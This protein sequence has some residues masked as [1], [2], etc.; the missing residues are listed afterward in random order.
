MSFGP[1]ALVDFK[2][3][4]TISKKSEIRTLTKIKGN[5]RNDDT[6]FA[7]VKEAID[8]KVEEEENIVLDNFE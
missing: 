1:R 7:L 8:E 4:Q 2:D 5:N 6:K 3:N